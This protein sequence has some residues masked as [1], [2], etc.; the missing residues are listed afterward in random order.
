MLKGLGKATEDHSLGY[1]LSSGTP[2]QLAFNA[3]LAVID[4]VRPK[5][6]VE[7]ML[8]AVPI[9]NL[10]SEILVM[11]S[12]QNWHRNVERLIGTLRRECLDHLLIYGERHLRRKHAVAAV[13]PTIW[14]HR[15]HTNLVRIASSLRADTIFGKDTRPMP[16]HLYDV[17]FDC[18]AVFDPD[19]LYSG[20]AIPLPD[21]EAV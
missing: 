18:F 7:G 17:S 8:A 9:G 11:Q 12:A 15:H 14:D 5:D 6:E 16:S 13:R 21:V 1:D 3:A 4:G 2:N 20:R 19:G 10:R